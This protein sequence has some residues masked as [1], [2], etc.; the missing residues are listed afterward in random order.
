[1][2]GAGAIGIPWQLHLQKNLILFGNWSLTFI[3]G[4]F[5]MFDR[6]IHQQIL[7]I[8]RL[9]NADLLKDCQAYFGGGTQLV[10]ELGEY[11]HEYAEI[12]KLREGASEWQAQRQTKF[13]QRFT[14]IWR[15]L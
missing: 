10:L 15:L 12:K 3:L 5:M 2:S 7:H 1:M 6:S 13:L 14:S 9:L 11:R 8:L 4:S